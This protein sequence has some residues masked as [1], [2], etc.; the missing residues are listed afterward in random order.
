MIAIDCRY[1]HS[2]SGSGFSHA[3]WGNWS[4]KRRSHT[5]PASGLLYST[6]PPGCSTSYGLIVASPTKISL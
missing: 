2:R 6:E 1:S 3:W 4:A 5:A